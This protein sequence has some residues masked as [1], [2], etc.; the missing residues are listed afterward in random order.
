MVIP[1]DFEVCPHC[2]EGRLVWIGVDS[3][4]Q[5]QCPICGKTT[6]FSDATVELLVDGIFEELQL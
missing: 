5:F 6:I 4:W 3:G 2:R 1:P